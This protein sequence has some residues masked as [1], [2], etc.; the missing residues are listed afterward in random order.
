[1]DFFTYIILLLVGGCFGGLMAGLL[2]VGGG[3]ILT[4]IQY[5]LLLGHMVLTLPLPC[6]YPLVQVWR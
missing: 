1:M 2:G 3:I 6:L 4:P 5:Y